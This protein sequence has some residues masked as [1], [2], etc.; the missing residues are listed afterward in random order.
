MLL[1]M[2][3]DYKAMKIKRKWWNIKQT[4]G[5]REQSRESHMVLCTPNEVES[6]GLSSGN[7]RVRAVSQLPCIRKTGKERDVH[8]SYKYILKPILNGLKT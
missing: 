3:I 6:H 2:K 4:S 5:S 8:L 7:Y 1:H